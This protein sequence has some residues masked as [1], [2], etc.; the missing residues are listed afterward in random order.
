[1]SDR[2]STRLLASL[3]S[4]LDTSPE[5][6]VAF[7]LTGGPAFAWEVSGYTLRCFSGEAVAYEAALQQ[8]TV[9]SLA[10]ALE[11]AGFTVSDKASA[12]TLAL[13]AAILMPA[14]G[15]SSISNSSAVQGYSS[16]TVALM[17]A[18]GSALTEAR[19][20]MA[21]ALQQAYQ[22]TASGEWLDLW[23]EVF[24]VQR[25]AQ[26]AADGSVLLESDEQYAPRMLVT[27]LRPRGNNLAI[28]RAVSDLVGQPVTVKDVVEAGSQPYGLFDAEVGYDLING[29]SVEE[30]GA[31]VRALV[32]T[33]RDAGTFLRALAM[34]GSQISDA[35]P[36]PADGAAVQALG[37]DVRLAD[38]VAAPQE[39]GP[40]V[41]GALSAMVDAVPAASGDGVA[42]G[43]AYATTYNGLRRYNGAV[44]HSSGSVS[45]ET[46]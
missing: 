34:V 31:K 27:A 35:V 5:P 29:G 4:A 37:G 46:I 16:L 33:M 28:A 10:A 8:H 11:A 23:G 15:G 3:Y 19:S 41:L 21:A 25:L 32:E 18:M 39:P 36:P 44:P 12:E 14:R 45:T 1:M 6:F 20:D 30:Y 2:H 17:E 43:L 38:A 7:R 42:L 13:G 24:G 22:Q 9:G 26:T 40:V